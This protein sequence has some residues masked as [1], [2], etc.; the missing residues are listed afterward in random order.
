M[1]EARH[2]TWSWRSIFIFK[3][4]TKEESL[5]ESK[6]FKIRLQDIW[7]CGIIRC[8]FTIR[9]ML[10][11]FLS[12]S[13]TLSSPSSSLSPSSSSSSSPSPSTLSSKTILSKLV[14]SRIESFKLVPPAKST[15]THHLQLEFAQPQPQHFLVHMYNLSFTSRSFLKV[16]S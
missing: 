15:I 13:L 9:K 4:S 1:E 16:C 5:L 8:M 14:A 12:W 3:M 7:R 10:P 2:T 6:E 11:N